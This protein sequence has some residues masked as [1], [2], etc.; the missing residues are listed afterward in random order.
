MVRPG[1]SEK[2]WGANLP[3]APAMAGYVPEDRM[4]I[5]MVVVAY[6]S[7]GVPADAVG[8]MR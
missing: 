1:D 6:W 3:A 7:D 5:L 8:G 2:T 4:T